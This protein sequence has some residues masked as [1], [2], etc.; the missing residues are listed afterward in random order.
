MKLNIKF[1]LLIVCL[2]AV[3][4]LGVTIYTKREPVKAAA[5]EQNQLQLFKKVLNIVQQSYVDKVDEKTLILGAINGMLTSLDPHNAFLTPEP[6]NEMKTE[7]SGSFG[8]IGTE[9]GIRNDRLIVI[10]PIEDTPAFK[11]GIKPNDFIWKIDDTLTNGLPINKAVNLMRGPKGT[12][13]TLHI[14]RE[15]YKNPLVFIIVRDI[16]KTKSVRSGVIEP[17]YGYIRISQFQ[18]TTGED[19]NNALRKLHSETPD[20][21]KG[22]VIDLRFNPGGLVDSA[23]AVANNFI[24]K[25]KENGTIVTLR[26]RLP[27]QEF[28]YYARVG[29]KEPDYPIVVL[30]NGGS[31]S[32]SEILAGALQ[33]NNKAVIMGTQSF[34]KGSVQSIIPLR[35][36]YALKLTTALYYTPRGRSIQAEGIT[37]DIIVSQ[38]EAPKNTGSNDS[39]ND[40]LG[41]REKD[42]T[43]HFKNDTDKSQDNKPVV[44]IK[45]DRPVMDD[46]QLFRAIEMLKEL[47]LISADNSKK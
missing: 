47:T 6:Y 42:L 39:K 25:N 9:I 10:S 36:G 7:L 14:I 30:I 27:G 40:E 1:I 12:K 29:G 23:V 18:E 43:N 5:S 32:A 26:G 35:Y 34:G 33:D 38:S 37:P 41:F 11:A 22:L 4:F 8:G 16:I 44:Q 20:G 45:N 46:Y 24:G 15:G 19:F 31:A 13:V 3:T 2:I 28:N 17:G 21:I